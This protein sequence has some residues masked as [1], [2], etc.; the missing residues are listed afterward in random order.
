[1]IA[2]EKTWLESQ[3]LDVSL[4]QNLQELGWQLQW[5]QWEEPLTLQLDEDLE[6]RWLSDGR[7]YREL[8]AKTASSEIFNSLQR[9]LRS[10]R[11]KK[12]PQRLIHQRIIGSRKFN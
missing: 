2:I 5:E 6:H 10:Q 3:R 1:L 12:L 8:I 4:G 9:T 7:P 11:G